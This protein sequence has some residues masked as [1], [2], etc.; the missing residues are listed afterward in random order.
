MQTITTIGLDLEYLA[1]VFLGVVVVR[2]VREISDQ[3]NALSARE[4]RLLAS[5]TNFVRSRGKITTHFPHK[6]PSYIREM[7]DAI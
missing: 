4:T 6:A 7:Y 1:D 5:S 2:S 3:L